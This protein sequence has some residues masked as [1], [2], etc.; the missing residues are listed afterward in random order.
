MINLIILSLQVRFTIMSNRLVFLLRRIPLLGKG[1]PQSLYG[2]SEAKMVFT[3]LGVLHILNMRL[4]LHLAYMA[5]LLITG[6][7][8]SQASAMGGIFEFLGSTESFANIDF[9]NVMLYALTS[10]FFFSFVG[11]PLYSILVGGRNHKNDNNMINYMRA[12]PAKYAQSRIFLDRIGDLILFLPTLLIVFAIAG[13]PMWGAL[14]TLLIFTSCRLLGETLN[15]WLYKICGKHLGQIPLSYIIAVPVY[16]LGFTGPYFFGVL[17]LSTIFN[18][19]FASTGILIASIVIGLFALH[20]I[21]NYQLYMNLL[22]DKLYILEAYYQKHAQAT[23][24]GATLAV[25]KNWSK[26]VTFENL[27]E[28]KFSHKSGF[29]YLN[30]IFFSRHWNFFR[31]KILTRCLIFLAPLAI[32]ILL[33]IYS[34]ILG[35]PLYRTIYVLVTDIVPAYQTAMYDMT[36]ILFFILSMASVGRVVTLSIFSNCDIHMMHY[37]YYR[38]SKTILASFRSRYMMIFAYNTLITTTIFVSMMGII[39]L[40]FGYIDIASA[41][42][43]FLALTAMSAFFSFSDLFLYYVIQPYDSGGK[44]KSILHKVINGGMGILAWQF[45]FNI[46]V[47]LNVFTIGLV[48]AVVVY[49]LIGSVLLMLLAPKRFKLR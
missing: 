32:V 13:L 36:P 24:G 11:A 33:A 22:K 28:D 48:G 45:L 18:N 37:P 31:K 8:L 34:L 46:R 19:F 10:W 40:I 25:A 23:A 42:V 12:N 5:I 38:T 49:L 6:I 20:Y 26:D 2:K 15:L 16:L 39:V 3:V 21:K 9:Q 30:A 14:I 7:V 1:I 35:E 47:G 44:D 41:G 4:M 29:A 27:E 43:F 17:P